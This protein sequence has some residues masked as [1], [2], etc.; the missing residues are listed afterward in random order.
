V[1]NVL[2]FTLAVSEGYRLFA[3]AASQ[4]LYILAL[5]LVARKE[6]SSFGKHG[7]VWPEETLKYMAVS[8][9]AAVLYGF[10]TTFVPGLLGG[11][12]VFPT[13]PAIEIVAVAFAALIASIVSEMIFRGYVQSKLT[14]NGVV[15][16][17]LLTSFMFSLYELTILPFDLSR[18]FVQTVSFFAL[19][20]CLGIL[21]IRTKTL[22]CPALFLFATSLLQTFTPVKA[23]ASD[24][25]ELLLQF[26]ASG[27]LLLVL[28]FT[29]E[30]ERPV[31]SEEEM[32]LDKN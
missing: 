5:V 9:L 13:P 20:A 3:Y 19:G 15:R 28:F 4:V 17:L 32:F 31:T 2:L 27:L 10:M 26:A 25:V 22:L 8:L 1:I 21:F 29:T 23:I 18:V 6:N 16:G 24:Y 12:D 11:Y 7:F 14:Q 30:T